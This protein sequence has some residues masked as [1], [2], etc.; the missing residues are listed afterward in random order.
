[1]KRRNNKGIATWLK[2]LLGIMAVGFVLCLATC[3]VVGYF[4]YQA[5]SDATNPDKIKGVTGS[6]VSMKE[7]PPSYSYVFGSDMFGVMPMV[8][9]KNEKA[10]MTYMIMRLPNKDGSS[11]T[12]DKLVEQMAEQGVQTAGPGAQGKMTMEVQDK[13]KTQVGGVEMPYIIGVS[14]NKSTGAKQPSFMGCVMPSPDTATLVVA[15]S[16]DTGAQKLDMNE[17]NSFLSNIESFKAAPPLPG[18]GK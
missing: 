5:F 6:I 7:L 1:M 4:G 10:K 15:G 2:W 13:G 9:L 3:G 16:E 8:L 14:E 12:A 18:A 17:V 11:M